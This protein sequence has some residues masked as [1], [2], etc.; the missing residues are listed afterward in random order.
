MKKKL[1]PALVPTLLSMRVVVWSAVLVAL[2]FALLSLYLARAASREYRSVYAKPVATSVETPDVTVVMPRGWKAY[3][4]APGEI[5]LFK[6]APERRPLVEVR[7]DRDPAFRFQALDLNPA[8][9]SRILF[10]QLDAEDWK[11]RQSGV[12]LHGLELVRVEPGIEGVRFAF[13][14]GGADGYALMCLS[15]DRRYLVW[16]AADHAD[17]ESMRE[18]RDFIQYPLRSFQLPEKSEAFARPVV[19]S[20][21][22]TAEGNRNVLDEVGRELAMWRLFSGRA[23]KE[24]GSSLLP[25]ISHFR[26]A[27][28][29][30]SSIRQESGLVNS[31]DFATYERLLDVR[32]HMVAEWFVLLDKCQATGDVDGAKRQAAYIAEHATLEGEAHEAQQANDRLKQLDRVGNGEGGAKR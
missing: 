31:P 28:G 8:L 5:R 26:K 13:S 14:Y 10:R 12:D 17:A 21:L 11:D 2:F 15:G 20:G 16:G 1:K 27:L 4:R 30:L 25:A 7:V 19:R 24:P 18:I 22:L 6:A 23:E 9:L 29:L 32:R 3:S